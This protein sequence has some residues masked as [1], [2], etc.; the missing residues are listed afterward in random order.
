[1]R[2]YIIGNSKVLVIN[3]GVS[4]LFSYNKGVYRLDY[5]FSFLLPS[6]LIP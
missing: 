1:M 5:Y 2:K 6:V 4:K 3:K